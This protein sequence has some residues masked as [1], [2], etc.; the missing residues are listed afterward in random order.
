V[1]RDLCIHVRS[2]AGAEIVVPAYL[3]YEVTKED[4]V[5]K[6]RT[7]E[8]YWELS[9]QLRQMT[10]NGL[11]GL[12]TSLAMTVRMVQ[13]QGLGFL[14][15]YMQA[16][17]GIGRAGHRVVAQLAAALSRRDEPA[18]AALL[19]AAATL[20]HPVGGGDSSDRGQT[21]L[22]AQSLLHSFPPDAAV[23]MER[24]ISAGRYTV[25]RYT[26]DSASQPSHGIGF[27]RFARGGSQLAEL[28]LFRAPSA[29]H[30]NV[31]KT[32][33]SRAPFD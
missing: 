33:A 13:N 16:L 27:G 15:G 8:A 1:V 2:A 20:E 28:R 25:F 19:A 14:W 3:R 29:R 4:G 31:L 23:R 26:V 22:T 21:A 12:R 7:L 10:A 6:L 30:A 24:P 11:R 5:L 32:R 9:G 18:L 17:L